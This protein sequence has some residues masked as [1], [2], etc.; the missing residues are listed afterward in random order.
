MENENAMV[1][2]ITLG[3]TVKIHA[4]TRTGNIREKFKEANKIMH[5]ETSPAYMGG[6]NNQ[7][8]RTRG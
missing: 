5:T 4:E 8:T 1:K 3:K 2:G 7:H 6:T